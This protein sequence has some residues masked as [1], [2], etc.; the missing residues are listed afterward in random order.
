MKF[1]FEIWDMTDCQQVNCEYHAITAMLKQA[2]TSSTYCNPHHPDLLK[3]IVILNEIEIVA[4][5]SLR[6]SLSLC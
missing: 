2:P 5:R 3:L 4:P 1:H 6:L